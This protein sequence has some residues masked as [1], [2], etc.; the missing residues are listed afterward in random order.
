MLYLLRLL[1]ACLALTSGARVAEAAAERGAATVTTEA[2]E[3]ARNVLRGLARRETRSSA[4]QGRPWTVGAVAEAIVALPRAFERLR[5][6]AAP[7][8]LLHRALLR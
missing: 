5:S 6:D 1:I 3:R 4:S 2:P 7:L 8:F